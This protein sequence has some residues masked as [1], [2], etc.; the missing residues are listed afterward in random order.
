MNEAF[1]SRTVS[2][3]QGLTSKIVKD[4]KENH[5]LIYMMIPV[6]LYYIIFHYV[7]MYGIIIAFKD[8]SITKGI[9]KSN[10][11]GL[12]HFADFFTGYYSWRLIRN[13]FLLSFY[14]VIFSFPLNIILA[15]L[16]NEVASTKF[17]RTVQTI[18]Y[19]PHFISIVVMCGIT[20]QFVSSQGLI[21]DII[22]FFGGE[23]TS[24]LLHPQYFRAIYIISGIW[25]EVGWNSIIYLAA[26]S[27]VDAQLYEAAKI[28]GANRFRQFL[29]VTLPGL[30]PTIII[31][32]ILQLSRIMS[33]GYEK[34]ILLYN[35]GIYET[36]DIIA[37]YVYRR[38]LIQADYSFSAAVG[39]F[40]T[41]I[42]LIFVLT[43]NTLSRKLTETSLW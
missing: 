37:S 32:L 33:Q 28:D 29:N 35:E 20:I 34:V 9:F 15:L 24:F 40:N 17:K 19:L 36:A 8:Y 4:Y 6:V 10:W 1:E 42:N 2:K 7:P 18:T 25:Q 41:T 11:V 27:G 38:G 23:R 43:A 31:L 22:A 39:L 30:L 21:N 26:L 3:K 5:V 16:L 13:T 12:K 14:G